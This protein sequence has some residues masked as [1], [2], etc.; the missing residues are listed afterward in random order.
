MNADRVAVVGVCWFV[1]W[2]LF[3]AACGSLL[4]APGT[5]IVSGFFLGLAA[6]IAWPWIMPEPI[7]R[8]MDA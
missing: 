2:T 8:W 4:G 1:L 6:M 3:G 7:N 5:G